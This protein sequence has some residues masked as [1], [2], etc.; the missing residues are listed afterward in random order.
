MLWGPK[1]RI[2][3]HTRHGE[4]P[5]TSFWVATSAPD[6]TSQVDTTQEE[7][8]AAT[9]SKVG[10]TFL[11]GVSEEWTVEDEAEL[12]HLLAENLAGVGGSLAKRA[13]LT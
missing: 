6:G 10:E 1:V 12:N 9:E 13:R 8:Q 5:A 7:E 4:Q 3:G 11:G 2:L